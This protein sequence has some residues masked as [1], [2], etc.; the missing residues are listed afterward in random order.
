MKEHAW[1]T[2]RV[3]AG[4]EGV[5]WLRDILPEK[6]PQARIFLYKYDASA[7]Y[8]KSQGTFI[9]KANELLD[10]IQIKREDYPDRP[11]ILLGHSMGGILI[12]QALINAQVNPD[13]QKIYNATYASQASG[14][15]FSI[16]IDPSG[17][18]L[19]SLL[20]LRMAVMGPG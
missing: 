11:L 4:E 2:W 7:A 12:E 3:P 16:D 15:L 19:H 18:L 8:S 9:D 14:K 20:L 5:L 6:V 13:Y 17:L 1:D 10:S